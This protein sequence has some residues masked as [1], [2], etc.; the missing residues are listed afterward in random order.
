RERVVENQVGQ[1]R[2][3][4][5]LAKISLEQLPATA[6]RSVAPLAA[7]E[8]AARRGVAQVRKAAG[9]FTARASGSRSRSKLTRRSARS[10]PAAMAAHRSK[11][12][13]AVMALNAAPSPTSQITSSSAAASRFNK[14]AAR[15]DCSM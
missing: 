14:R 1:R 8:H 7:F 5:R 11:Q 15:N 10:A 2:R 6:A 9:F 12:R 3:I 13:I 4:D